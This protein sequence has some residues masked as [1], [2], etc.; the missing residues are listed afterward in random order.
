MGPAPFFLRSLVTAS[1]TDCLRPKR[2]TSKAPRGPGRSREANF[3]RSAVYPNA[4]LCAR[5]YPRGNRVDFLR[6][7]RGHG[8][9]LPARNRSR[10]PR[11][12]R[13]SLSRRESLVSLRV[14]RHFMA[15]ISLPK[16]AVSSYQNRRSVPTARHAAGVLPL[17]IGI[18]T[19]SQRIAIR[20][21]TSPLRTVRAEFPHFAPTRG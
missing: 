11:L 19:L 4:R 9:S 2:K 1:A 15:A 17:S 7:R 14:P 5:T 16:R 21:L 18:G 8:L 12:E 10:N 6:G 20:T 3:S 13:I